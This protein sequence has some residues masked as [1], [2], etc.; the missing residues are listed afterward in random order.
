MI[1]P[2]TNHKGETRAR[3]FE[4]LTI[5]VDPSPYYHPDASILFVCRDN[6][7]PNQEPRSWDPAGFSK[8]NRRAIIHAIADRDREEAPVK[9]L[10][11]I[12][13]LEGD[14]RSWEELKVK[15]SGMSKRSP[16]AEGPT[17]IGRM[18]EGLTR[19]LENR[20]AGAS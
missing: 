3:D 6:E 15:A 7:R 16:D 17:P 20:K 11:T 8:D 13:E 18:I 2:Y 14:L 1:A 19:E 10:R 5:S 9:L 12:E 4:P